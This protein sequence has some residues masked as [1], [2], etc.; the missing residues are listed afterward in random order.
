MTVEEF[1]AT[2]EEVPEHHD[3]SNSIQIYLVFSHPV[4]ISY[5]T[6]R[7]HSF[8]VTAGEVSYVKRADGPVSKR[9]RVKVRPSSNTSVVITLPGG[10]P[11]NVKGAVCVKGVRLSNSSE[12]TADGPP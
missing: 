4:S 8:E 7:D 11:C 3:G 6:L 5:K 12:A 1:T 2:L 9:W 10:R